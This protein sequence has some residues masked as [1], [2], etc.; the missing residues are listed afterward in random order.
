MT[1]FIDVHIIL[2]ASLCCVK[3]Q[4][5]RSSYFK[6]ISWQENVAEEEDCTVDTQVHD[7]FSCALTCSSTVMCR[8][9][10]FDKDSKK[11]SFV[12]ATETL[13]HQEG[14]DL[15]SENILFEKVGQLE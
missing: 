7:E 10:L 13:T 12:K 15:E 6:R 5:F 14:E 4:M 2:L 3:M 11:C 9:A 1:F 8:Y